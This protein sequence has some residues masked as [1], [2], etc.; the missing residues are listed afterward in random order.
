MTCL[1]CH[2][3]PSKCMTQLLVLK[4]LILSWEL[5]FELIAFIQISPQCWHGATS[6]CSIQ[7]WML[8]R[9]N[10]GLAVVPGHTNDYRYQYEILEYSTGLFVLDDAFP[11]SS[12]MP[13]SSLPK[14]VLFC[15][16]QSSGPAPWNHFL[17]VDADTGVQHALFSA[18]AS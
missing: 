14:T 18:A 16:C 8:W 11:D 17:T 3:S 12:L 7:R 10:V 9:C 13:S 2:Q 5:F 15:S 4:E 1:E 6:P